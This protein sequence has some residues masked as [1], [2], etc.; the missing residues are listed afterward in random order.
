MNI[1]TIKQDLKNWLDACDKTKRAQ[2][3][4]NHF[5]SVI[6][7][8]CSVSDYYENYIKSLRFNTEPGAKENQTG[9]YR[10]TACFYKLEY[11]TESWLGKDHKYL[12]GQCVNT[13]RVA[14]DEKY[15]RGC[16]HCGTFV[17]YANLHRKLETAQ[18]NQEKSRNALLQN[19]VFWKK[20]TKIG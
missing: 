16:P 17:E 13:C 1:A 15:C 8:D 20:K 4:L 14:V 7:E 3:A 5:A 19:F 9:D 18:A 12:A 2:Y 10:A 11:D 6:M